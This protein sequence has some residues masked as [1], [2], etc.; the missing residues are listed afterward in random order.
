MKPNIPHQV[1]PKAWLF[2]SSLSPHLESLNS[3]LQSG[4]YTINTNKRYVA[5]IAHF[6]YWRD[7]NKLKVQALDEC[8]VEEFLTGHLPLCNC[9]S[10]VVRFQRDM[11]ACSHALALRASPTGDNP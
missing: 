2:N 6:A 1:N 5:C 9:P 3:H 10:P 4:R 11:H 8:A 7:Q